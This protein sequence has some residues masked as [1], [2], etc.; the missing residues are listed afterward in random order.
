MDYRVEM[1]SLRSI[2]ALIYVSTTLG[3]LNNLNTIMVHENINIFKVVDD[4]I[5]MREKNTKFSKVLDELEKLAKDE[6]FD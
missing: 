5:Q 1:T 3:E 6:W 2:R 4:I